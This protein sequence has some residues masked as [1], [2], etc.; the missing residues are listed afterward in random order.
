MP[1]P[2]PVP[3]PPLYAGV[4][5]FA[6]FIVTPV[7]GGLFRCGCDWPW[8]GLF[9]ACHS[10]R[11]LPPGCPWCEHP[12]LGLAAVVLPVA[13]GIAACRVALSLRGSRWGRR[14]GMGVALVAGWA[15]VLAGLYFIGALTLMIP[16]NLPF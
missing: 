15:G 13:A 12:V 9:L 7:C 4:V 6:L 10:L 11:G 1:D 8:S 3:R 16:G 14:G 5:L 2:N